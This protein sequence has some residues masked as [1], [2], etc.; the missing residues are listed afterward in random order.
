[1]K[2]TLPTVA[3]A[4]LMTAQVKAAVVDAELVRSIAWAESRN[5]DIK[6]KAGE[7]SPL[8]MR[9][10]AVHQAERWMAYQAKRSP[11]MALSWIIFQRF[12]LSREIYAIAYLDWLNLQYWI[13]HGENP[14]TRQLVMLWNAPE[15][16]KRRKF[17]LSAM[18]KSTRELVA[19]FEKR[20]AELGKEQAR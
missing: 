2:R 12:P 20:Y 1:M 15:L 19:R 6:G 13:E 5:K 14:T 3:A 10:I 16:S 18:P 7:V 8:Q 17:K 9:E 11:A 4:M